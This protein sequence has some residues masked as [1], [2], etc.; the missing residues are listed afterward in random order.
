MRVSLCISP[1]FGGSYLKSA[2]IALQK[3]LSNWSSNEQRA[4]LA[5]KS[6]SELVIECGVP[7]PKQTQYT[8]TIGCAAP[9]PQRPA[10]TL[11]SPAARYVPVLLAS[12]LPRCVVQTL[13]ASSSLLGVSFQVSLVVLCLSLSFVVTLCCANRASIALCCVEYSA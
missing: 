10:I 7:S 6:P 8:C 13:V 11:S 2:C 3:F 4:D 12:C 9:S 1:P 5:T